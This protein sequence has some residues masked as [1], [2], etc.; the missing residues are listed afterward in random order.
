MTN[1]EPKVNLLMHNLNTPNFFRK[2]YCPQLSFS[3]MTSIR[4]DVCDETRHLHSKKE[5]IEMAKKKGSKK[6]GK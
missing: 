3:S 5:V 4:K 6:K 1:Q 2:I